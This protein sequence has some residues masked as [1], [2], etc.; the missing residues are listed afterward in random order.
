MGVNK[1]KV[2]KA[3]REQGKGYQA[4]TKMRNQVTDVTRRP[5][6][7]GPRCSHMHNE[8][9]TKR[10]NTKSCADISE[11]DRRNIF[12]TFWDMSWDQ[13]KVYIS[14]LV[15]ISDKKRSKTESSRR[16]NTYMYHYNL[17]IHNV[18]YPVCKAMFLSTLS[19]GEWSVHA[20][21]HRSATG[22]QEHTPI[23]MPQMARKTTD[24]SA[25]E[26][27]NTIPKVESHYCRRDSQK[28]YVEPVFG[29]FADLYREYQVY[30]GENNSEPSSR[31]TFR[32]VFNNM[33]MSLY[34]PK[35]DQCDT[36]CQYKEGNLARE[37]YDKHIELKNQARAQ[38]DND[39]TRRLPK[40]TR[41]QLL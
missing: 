38:Q 8:G 33:N 23:P 30:C 11:A 27:L 21:V 24:G 3:N 32:T 17:K 18:I 2:N 1:R 16:T 40:M 34:K 28:Q 36:C 25:E 31:S 29:S 41:I 14:T 10:N 6:E 35:K 5:R 20:W 13:R 4:K 15:T 26:F 7:L 9:N 39:N 37:A 19:I 12:T 22:M